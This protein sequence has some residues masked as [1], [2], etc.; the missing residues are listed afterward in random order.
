[1]NENLD[2]VGLLL[3]VLANRISQIRVQ[4]YTQ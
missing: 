2:Y 1:M 3:T 4:Y